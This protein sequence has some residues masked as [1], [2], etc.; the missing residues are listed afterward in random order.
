VRK[1]RR[2]AELGEGKRARVERT[3]INEEKS[4]E[5]LLRVEDLSGDLYSFTSL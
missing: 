1:E 3:R 5:T 2:S 4:V